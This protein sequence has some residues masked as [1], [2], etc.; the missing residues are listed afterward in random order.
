M[1]EL[2]TYFTPDHLSA[3]FDAIYNG[4]FDVIAE[5]P[6]ISTGADR[7]ELSL[8]ER[9]KEKHFAAISRKVLR[10]KYAF[11]PFLE[12]QI[13]KPESTE[14][15]TI[16][17]A[18]I[19]DS[20]VQRA[21]YEYVY[22]TVDERLSS[23]IFGYRRGRSAHDAV[24]L[25]RRFYA[26]GLTFVFDA[27]LRQFFDSVDHGVLLEMVGQ[28]GLDERVN[29][30]IRRFLKT[31][32]IP[33][34]QVEEHKART[35][36]KEKYRPEPRQIG[37]PQGGV[38]SGLLANLYLSP[39]DREIE[40]RYPG[41]V[42]YADD[43]LVCCAHRDECAEVHRLVEATLEPLRVNL[44]GDKTRECVLAESG[45]DFLGFRISTRGI[46]VRGRNV[47]KFKRRIQG[48]LD[49]QRIYRSPGATLRSLAR[50]LQFKIRGP[51]QDQLDRMAERGRVISPCRRSWIGF[52]R[53][54]DDLAQIRALDRW[55]RRQV[56]K[57]M[58]ER[59]RCRVGLGAM[60]GCG[61]PSLVNSL[62][63]ARSGEQRTLPE[64]R[65]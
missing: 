57:F 4:H 3:V 37:V 55:I 7:I 11:S 28:L 50:R 16:S 52:F 2:E 61:M 44:N 30:L 48:V 9:D 29:T 53:I 8:F 65:E 21:L 36:K 14:M 6:R 15:R 13:P 26:N 24:R 43:F 33:S 32:R 10:G 38:L 46:R 23:A 64:D 63:K 49:T 40:G 60:Q 22:P 54:V 47:T 62:W 27:D 20:V 58:W 5:R 1:P 25:I 18:S 56:S 34:A 45:V 42:R 35:G 12:R 19:R 41:Y 51:S 17:V 39:L 59:H 31:G